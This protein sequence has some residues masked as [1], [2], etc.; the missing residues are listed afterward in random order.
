MSQISRGEDNK[1]GHGKNIFRGREAHIIPMRNLIFTMLIMER[2]GHMKKTHAESHGR[3]SKIR[4]IQK[5]TK[6]KHHIWRKVKHL[7]LLIIL[8]IIAI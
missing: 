2:M 7:N 5:K 4:N 1:R 6:V 3:I 8:F